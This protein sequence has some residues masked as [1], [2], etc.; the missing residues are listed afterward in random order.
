MGGAFARGLAQ[1]TL[2]KQEEICVSNPSQGK[3]DSLKADF[4]GIRITNSNVDCVQGAELIVLAV[5]PWIAS[6]VMK[7][8]APYLR[9]IK[10]QAKLPA[11]ASMVGGMSLDDLEQLVGDALGYSS[12][13]VTEKNSFPPLACLIPNTAIAVAQSMTFL[14]T[15]HASTK[16][17]AEFLAVLQELGDAMLVRPDQMAGGT[18]LASCG[19][20]FAMR[21]LRAATEGG[22]Q[23]GFYPHQAQRI[24]MQTLKGMVELLKQNDSHPE[25]EIDRVT[26]P[27]GIT[28]KGLNAM[29]R[30]GFTHAVIEGLLAAKK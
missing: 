17:D 6:D 29:E 26:T 25:T 3:L 12:P 1:G 19:I 8:M 4:P 5:K 30:A 22:V 16:F 23:L 28:I 18:A 2:I 13:T 7:E 15:R 24:V 11:I 20:A 9:N 10:E 14:S 21:Y 27:G